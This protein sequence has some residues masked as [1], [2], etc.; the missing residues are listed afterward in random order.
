LGCTDGDVTNEDY[1]LLSRDNSPYFWFCKDCSKL[2]ATAV[3]NDKLIETKCKEYCQGLKDEFSAKFSDIDRQFVELRQQLEAVKGQHAHTGGIE[4]TSRVTEM[5]KKLEE[6]E[7]QQKKSYSQAVQQG[8]V[9]ATNRSVIETS[10][11][12]VEDR[13]SRKNKLVWFGIKESTLD[14][15]EARKQADL[16]AVSQLGEKVFSFS[17]DG[18]FVNAKRLGKKGEGCR[19]LLTTLASVEQAQEGLIRAKELSHTAKYLS[20]KI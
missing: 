18:T 4:V 7:G 10:A 9:S 13:D 8:S 1:A 2:A 3:K 6:L 5:Q 14:D 20:R 16:D 17:R 11:R 15:G 12:E 19:P